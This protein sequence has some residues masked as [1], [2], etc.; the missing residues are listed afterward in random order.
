MLPFHI[1]Q[2]LGFQSKTHGIALVN[3]KGIKL[4]FRDAREIAAKPDAD[5][6]AIMIEWDNVAGL[7][8]KRGIMA[9]GLH[10][11]VFAMLGDEP[12]GKNDNVIQLEVPKRNREQ[13]DRFEKLVKEYQT[14]KRKDDVDDVLDDVRDLLDRM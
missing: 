10:I 3:E 2:M 14:G 1:T 12:D 13:L 5:A 7:E 11:K 6:D 9:D 4:V 8:F